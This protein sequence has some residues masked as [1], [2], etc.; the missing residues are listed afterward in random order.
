MNGKLHRK[1]VGWVFLIYGLVG[2]MI[3]TGAVC[4][5]G[6]LGAA[7]FS[8]QLGRG[9]LGDALAA[10]TATFG[11]AAILGAIFGGLS[12]P[13]FLAGYGILRRRSWGRPIGMALAILNLIFAPIGTIFGLYALWV[14]L[15]GYE[16]SLSA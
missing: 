15:V 12:L 13:H 4:L 5:Y 6:G 7:A 1:V 9:E 11:A 3:T 2:L 16:D 10:L 8:E 14:L